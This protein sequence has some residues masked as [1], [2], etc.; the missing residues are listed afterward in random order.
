MSPE[1]LESLCIKLDKNFFQ[2]KHDNLIEAL[3]VIPDIQ[4]TEEDSKDLKAEG[5]GEFWD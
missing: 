4:V 2:L 1:K 3:K 5:F